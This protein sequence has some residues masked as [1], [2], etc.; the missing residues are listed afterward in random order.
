MTP[1]GFH[2]VEL[3]S[4]VSLPIK[5]SK[6][7]PCESY[8]ADALLSSRLNIVMKDAGARDTDDD[9]GIESPEPEWNKR[10]PWGD[11]LLNVIAFRLQRSRTDTIVHSRSL[12]DCPTL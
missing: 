6:Y 8:I 9:I 10:A 1:L 11:E 2:K 5:V 7:V 12:S 3:N 4:P